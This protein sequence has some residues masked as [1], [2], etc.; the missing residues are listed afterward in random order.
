MWERAIPD[1]RNIELRYTWNDFENGVDWT[2]AEA[3]TPAILHACHD[4]RTIAF[5]SYRLS[6]EAE[7]HNPIYVDLN[8]D[9]MVLTEGNTL[10]HLL[11]SSANE[12]FLRVVESLRLVINLTHMYHRILLCNFAD[13][14]R[15][16]L[17]KSHTI[18][19]AAFKEILI[20]HP[21]ATESME[22]HQGHGFIGNKQIA[23]TVVSCMRD[24]LDRLQRRCE[25]F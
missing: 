1:A 7:L 4:S 8:R 24:D 14:F 23:S 20:L 17:R 6:F 18:K 13:D 19:F 16:L 5:K 25:R 9:P 22:E 21:S 10:D 11:S 3:Q 2:F 15:Y 12:E